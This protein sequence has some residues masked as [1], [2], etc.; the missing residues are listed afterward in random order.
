MRIR[1]S[2]ATMMVAASSLIAQQPSTPAPQPTLI[3]GEVQIDE[4]CRVLTPPRPSA[5]DPRP[6]FRF[7]SIV[8]HLE[9]VHTSDHWEQAPPTTSNGRPRRTHVTVS[10][11]EFLLQ[12]ITSDPVTFVVTQR[13][14]KGWCIDSEPQPTELTPTSAVFRVQ[15][16]PRQIVRLHVGERT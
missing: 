1:I 6:R 12:N 4:S 5:H 9:S 11:R 2:A 13:L 10:E 7:N 8:C 15:A 3:A 14:R 16:Q